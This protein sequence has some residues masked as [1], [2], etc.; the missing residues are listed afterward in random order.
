MTL[1]NP[2][3]ASTAA[4]APTDIAEGTNAYCGMYYKAVL[5]DYCNML[6]LRF[7]ITIDDFLFLN[8]AVNTNCTNLFAEESYC[9]QAVGDSKFLLLA[10]ISLTQSCSQYISWSSWRFSHSNWYPNHH[11]FFRLARC[12]NNQHNATP[13]SLTPC[14][15]NSKR[16]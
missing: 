9:V 15:W 12:D 1:I 4:A 6:I 3:S 16:L 8:P 11:R 13:Y 7:K 14:E 2:T 5:G 10:V